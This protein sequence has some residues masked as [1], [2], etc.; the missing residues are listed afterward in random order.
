MTIL[1]RLERCKVRDVWRT[2]N[3]FSDWLFSEENIELLSES[4]GLETIQT[5]VREDYVGNFKADIFGEESN[6]G[7]KVIIEN[8]FEVSNHDHLGKIITY[9]AGKDASLIIW[10]V[11][12]ARPEHA[13][14]IEWLNNN[15]SG[16][17]FFLVE[18]ELWRIGDSQPAPKFNIVERPNEWIQVE[19]AEID[20]TKKFK[21]AYWQ[22][23]I[24]YSKKNKKFQRAYPGTDARK[25][26][27]DH[28]MSFRKGCK[29]NYHIESKIYTRNGELISVGTDV[30]ISDDK[31]LY[32]QFESHKEEIE[33][34]LGYQMQWD[35]KDSNK[36]SSI[37]IK[38]NLDE[39]ETYESTFEWFMEKA[40]T[41]RD[42]FNKYV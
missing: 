33:S 21:Y 4:L 6:T 20:T 42:V 15:M 26:S 17:G 8:Q 40:V 7:R 14:A 19:K 23:F 2:E 11:E 16:K 27:A 13:S 10:V 30:W 18:I 24:E 39:G 36:A 32:R 31:E 41:L 35:C 29:G 38:R 25:P 22:Q 37:R 28:W 9:A 5:Q 34:E 3:E 1:G 12:E